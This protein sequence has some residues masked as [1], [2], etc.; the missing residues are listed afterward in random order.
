MSSIKSSHDQVLRIGF[1]PLVDCAPIALAHETGIFEKH[2]LRVELR[3]EPGWASIRDK[4]TFGA[5]E[6]VHAPLGMAFA[7]SWG[8]GVL[9]QPCVTGYLINSNGDAITISKTLHEAGVTGP[10]S[11]ASEI[12]T[13]RRE[14]PV[15][16]GVPHQFSSH[17]FLL[18]EWLRPAGL[19]VGRDFQIVMLPP[20]LMTSSLQAGFIDG[21]CVGEPFN[22]QAVS[23]GTGSVVAESAQLFPKHPEKALIVKESFAE[24]HH[25]THIQLIRAISEAA[26]LCE[27]PDGRE[28]IVGILARPNYLGI[29]PA[30]IRSSLFAGETSDGLVSEKFHIFHDEEV[31]CPAIEKANWLLT[32]AR[33]AGLLN[34]ADAIKSFPPRRILREDIYN[35]AMVPAKTTTVQTAFA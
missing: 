1:V 20:S 32:Q 11:L 3:R 27:T 24:R 9:P 35:E 14:R 21:Y 31:N 13:S 5:L 33:L 30:L 26:E 4:M 15:T 19:V 25:D 18:L 17:H 2:D 12:K 16:F 29:D 7:M 34:D 28:E 8:L 6:A 23:A 10:E 22:S